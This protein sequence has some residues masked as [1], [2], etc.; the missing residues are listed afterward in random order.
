MKI[1]DIVIREGDWVTIDGHTGNIYVGTVPTVETELIP[2]VEELLGWADGY[3]RL[4]VRANAD[5]PEDAA[6]VRKF[7]AQGIGL[8]RIERMFRKPERLEFLRSIILAES[9]RKRV[10]IWRDSTRC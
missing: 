1:D 3:R 8:L 9:R 4:G 2:E 7:G 10:P 5:L 6:I